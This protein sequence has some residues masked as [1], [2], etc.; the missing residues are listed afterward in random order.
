M[1]VT[2]FV[3]ELEIGNEA[4]RLPQHIADALV[5]AA[6]QLPNVAMMKGISTKVKDTLGNTIGSWSYK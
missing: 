6:K 5:A 1:A 4:M 3:L 2:R